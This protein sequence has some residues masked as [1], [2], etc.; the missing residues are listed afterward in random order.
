MKSKCI[1]VEGPQGCGKTTLTNYLREN[2]AS[3]NLYRLTGQSDKTLTGKEKSKNMYYAL[4]NYMKSLENCDVNLIF[5]RTFFSEQVYAMLGYK[6]YS[7][8]D[9]YNG[10]LREL[11]NLDF[12]I[13]YINLY[14]K[15]VDLFKQRL[16][17]PSHHGYHTFSLETSIKQQNMYLSLIPQIEKLRNTT[18]Y[19]LAMDDFEEAYAQI[20]E[21]LEIKTKKLTL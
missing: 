10:L 21:I 9:V 18:V 4:L 20:N 17:R 15:N 12:N 14:L 13:Y 3:S 16:D 11:G 7:F 19:K 2:I 8:T 5:D 1:I 6:E